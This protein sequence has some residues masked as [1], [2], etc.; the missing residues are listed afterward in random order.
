MS[1]LIRNWT[2]D[3]YHILALVCCI[4]FIC[5]F[6]YICIDSKEKGSGAKNKKVKVNGKR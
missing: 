6:I 2:W 3:G 5:L 4:S 1:D